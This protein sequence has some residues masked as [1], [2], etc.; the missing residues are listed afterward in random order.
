MTTEQ[1]KRLEANPDIKRRYAREGSFGANKWVALPAAIFVLGLFGT[2]FS[3][4]TATKHDPSYYTIM[5]VCIAVALCSFIIAA[6]M[7]NATI[8]RTVTNVNDVAAHAAR[9]MYGND[10]SEVYY[11]IYTTGKKR[12]DV[13]F[14]ETIAD[15]IEHIDE[16]RD[17]ELRRKVEKLFEPKLEMAGSAPVLLPEALTGGEQVYQRQLKFSHLVDSITRNNRHLAVLTFNDNSTAV[18][19]RHEDLHEA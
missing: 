10:A 7:Q 17:P 5:Y 3:Y 6:V 2:Y 11:C 18:I 12:H 8:K 16:E 1:L 15:R 4:S 13:D 9:R 19:V 14:I